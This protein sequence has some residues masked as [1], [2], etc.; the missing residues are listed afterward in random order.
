MKTQTVPTTLADGRYRLGPTLGRGGMGAVY[1][2]WD[3]RDAVARA[4]KVLYPIEDRRSDLPRRF[5]AE[6]AMLLSLSH[7]NVVRVFDVGEDGP[8]R[9]IVMELCDG[10]S[11]VDWIARHG[12]MPARLA[13]DVALQ[14]CAGLGAVHAAGFVHR[15][16]KPANVLV[17]HE[18]VC[19]LADF[20]I[21]RPADAVELNLTRT[22]AVFGTM[23]Y[24]APEQRR[25]AKFVDARSDVYAL[26]A[27]LHTLITDRVEMDLFAWATNPEIFRDV[28]PPVAAVLG[29]A[30]SYV[31]SLRYRSMDAFAAALMAIQPEL[32]PLPEDL[33]SL[34]VGR[35]VR[36]TPVTFTHE[37]EAPAPDPAEIAL[38]RQRTVLV[39]EDDPML[40]RLAEFV[41]SDMMGMHVLTAVDGADALK[42]NDAF[43]G[44]LDLVLTDLVMPGQHGAQVATALRRARPGLRVVYMSAHTRDRLVELGMEPVGGRL[45]HKPFS[46][47]DLVAAIERALGT[48]SN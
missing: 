44:Y 11:P 41:L 4:V 38:R 13:V 29:R 15:D 22:G 45:L 5:V 34:V 46:P 2:A 17:T 33:A 18:G 28:P 19:K 20:G 43:A 14:L 31:P 10:G 21:A 36:Q 27:T 23:G 1:E 7:D 25:S 16:V 42:V 3:A 8:W 24:M 47:Q 40:L 30:L 48:E 6:G 26:G 35:V 32:P 37:A 9:Y 39:V 12:P